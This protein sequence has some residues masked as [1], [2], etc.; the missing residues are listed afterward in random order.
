MPITAGALAAITGAAQ[1]GGNLISN[2]G[3]KKIPRK[4]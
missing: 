2:S 4:S 3:K 1:L